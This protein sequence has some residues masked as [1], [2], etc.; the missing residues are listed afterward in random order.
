VVRDV[1]LKVATTTS[2]TALV[3]GRRF[4]IHR[5]YIIPVTATSFTV[6]PTYKVIWSDS[7]NDIVSSTTLASLVAFEHTEH[8]P[9]ATLR[10]FSMTTVSAVLSI[11]AGATATTAKADVHVI[12]YYV[13]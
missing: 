9:I 12:G 11:T 8:S 3:S 13:T 4:I 2:I 10:A 6:S 5:I 1:D 7:G